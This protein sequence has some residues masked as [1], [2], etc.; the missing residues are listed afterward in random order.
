MFTKIRLAFSKVP[1]TARSIS[2]LI[3]SQADSIYGITVS[4]ACV[5]ILMVGFVQVTPA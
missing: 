1:S 3:V 2:T 4:V 5:A